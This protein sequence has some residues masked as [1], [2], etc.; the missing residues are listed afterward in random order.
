VKTSIRDGRSRRGTCS[1]GRL[2]RF[3]IIS[4][5]VL[6]AM[7]YAFSQ[8]AFNDPVPTPQLTI[9]V[10]NYSQASA[11]VMARAEREADRIFG[12]AGFSAVW[13]NCFAGQ[14]AID[15]QRFCQKTVAATHVNLRILPAPVLN[16]FQNSLFGFAVHPVLAS[17][18]YEYVLRLA[19]TDDAEFELP[20]ILGCAIAHEIGHLLLGPD[21]HSGTGIMQRNW[22]R[23][24]LRKAMM[25]TLLFT[26]EQSKV[27][28]DQAQRRC[29]LESCR[30]QG[31]PR[32][33]TPGIETG[34][35][36]T[37]RSSCEPTCWREMPCLID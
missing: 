21:S 27:I 1:T 31:Q 34:Q 14:S 16:K 25:G 3:L 10:D 5:G 29:F 24:Q 36:F 6:G 9:V 37:R 28:R 18:Y 19:K 30:P 13:L 22:E 4:A 17:V 7:G 15:T 26:S 23:E 35:Q 2:Q 20:I 32:T 33:S 8:T 12:K 11:A